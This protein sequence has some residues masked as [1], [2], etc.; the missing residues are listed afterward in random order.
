MLNRQPDLSALFKFSHLESD[1]RSHLAK[2]YAALTGCMSMAILGCGISVV[3]GLG[4]IGTTILAII[5]LIGMAFSGEKS[6][7][8]PLFFFGFGFFKGISLGP[9]VAM[10]LALDP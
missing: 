4:G 3:Y 7:F 2:T 9:L 8:K 6:F 5:C 10:S 1:V